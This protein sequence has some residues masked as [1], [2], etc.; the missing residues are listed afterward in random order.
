[1]IEDMTVDHMTRKQFEALPQREPRSTPLMCTAIVILPTRRMHD[2]GYRC[3]DFVAVDDRNMAVCRLSGWSDVVHIDGIGGLSIRR[4]IGEKI[5]AN[6][7][8]WSIDCLKKSGLLRLFT[9][10]PIEAG[11]ALS[12]FEIFQRPKVEE[13]Q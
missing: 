5:P 3:M 13:G 6:P 10:T 9:G 8:G 4:R 2:S 12:S 1:M 11:E 7:H